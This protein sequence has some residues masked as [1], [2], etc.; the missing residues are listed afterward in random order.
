MRIIDLRQRL[1]DLGAK[2][3]HSQRLLRQW[4]MALPLTAG[5][6]Q[7]EHWLPLAVRQGL[8]ALADE[9]QGLARLQSQHPGEDGSA[10]LLVAL[11]DGQTVESVL[12][13][14]GRTAH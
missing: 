4:V 14:P 2:P 1:Q 10:R 7:P 8:P 3:A 9:L 11:A 6:R 12:L 5:R 13:P